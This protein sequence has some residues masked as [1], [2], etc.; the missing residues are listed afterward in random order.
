MAKTIV[1][2]VDQEHALDMMNALKQ[3]NADLVK[4]YP[5][6]V[7]RVVS[8]EG[9][10]G[11][12]HLDD[13]QDPEKATPVILTT[14]Q[15]LTTGVDAPT[16]ANVVLFKPV[17]AMTE[18]KQIIGRGTRVAEDFDKF[19]FTILDYTGATRLFADPA[20]DG[21]PLVST[22][23]TIDE[24]GAVTSTEDET[25]AEAMPPAEVETPIEQ[26]TRAMLAS[27][28]QRRKFYVDGAEVWIMGQQAFELD[29]QGNVLRTAHY[30]DYTRENVR[31]LV[32]S[33]GHLREAWPVAE[34]RAEILDALRQRGVDLDA[35]AEATHQPEADPLDL[36]LH[37]AFSGP[38]LSRRERAQQLRSKRPNFFNTFTPAAREVLD[39]L[40]DK[41]A[42]FGLSQLTEWNDVLKIP[43][44]SEKGT[45]LEIAALFGGPAEMKR[46]VEQMQ[47]Y[48]YTDN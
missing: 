26:V 44:L 33:A 3:E 38:L 24:T 39:I 11:R 46:A 34:R 41:Y 29:P 1:F 30:T 25:S 17:N 18:F 10:V 37:V 9:K 40:L 27:D 36:L 42:D 28:P 47:T 14:S 23:Q 4:K 32:P 2:C 43:P 45:V 6:Y 15:M 8:D 13:F 35:L 31:R 19:W 21:E 20:F 16:C 7:A 22:H 5:H 48:L 12:G